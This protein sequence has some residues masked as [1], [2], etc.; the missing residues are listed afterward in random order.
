MP[1]LK[2]NYTPAPG[3]DK[4]PDKRYNNQ[5]FWANARKDIKYPGKTDISIQPRIPQYIYDWDSNLSLLENLL[6]NPDSTNILIEYQY[7]DYFTFRGY[8]S[9]VDNFNNCIS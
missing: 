6:V 5:T 3:V 9:L 2:L 7:R 8:L 1:N 4:P